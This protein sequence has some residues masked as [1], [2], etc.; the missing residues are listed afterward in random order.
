M[1]MQLQDLRTW[2]GTLGRRDYTLWGF[3]LFAVKYNVDRGV[4][5]LFAHEPWFPWSYLGVRGG[6]A[7]PAR[8]DYLQLELYWLMALLALPFVFWGVS[9]TLRRLRDAGWP[10]TLLLLFFVPFVNLLFFGLLC[11]Q[12]SREPPANVP[13]L[14]WWQRLLPMESRVVAAALGI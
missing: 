1:A 3:V 11:L 7:S 5:A 8:S 2:Q 10:Q 14:R 4:V 9:M 12:P 6:G 13:P